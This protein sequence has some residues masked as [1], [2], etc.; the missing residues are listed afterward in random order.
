MG[1]TYPRIDTRFGL[2]PCHCRAERHVRRTP[3]DSQNM[4]VAVVGQGIGDTCI[5]NDKFNTRISRQDADGSAAGKEVQHHLCR[6][7][8]RV[9]RY[10]LRD[11]AMI[12]GGN[13]N[14][15]VPW[16][17]TFRLEY[18]CELNGERF[19]SAKTAGRLGESVLPEL[20]CS[21]GVAVG[22]RDAGHHIFESHR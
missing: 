18:S 4:Q 3:A 19:E 8:L 12:G 17:G 15:F 7:L 22:R 13:D 14:R 1:E 6:D 10:A 11:Y 9:G 5:D 20:G 16:L 21:H 2:F